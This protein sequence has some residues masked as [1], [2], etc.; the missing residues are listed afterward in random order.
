MSWIKRFASSLRGGRLEQELD[1]ELEFH[2][3]MR[4]REKAAGGATPE[5]ARRQALQRFGS[6]TRAKEACRDESTIAWVAAVRQDLRYAARNLRKNPGFAAAAVTCLAMGIG[7]NAAV[8]SFVNAF[9][10]PALPARVVVV[11]RASGGLISYPELRDWRSLS[12]VFDQVFAY[13]PG[14]RFT[15]GRGANSRHVLGESVTAGY[16]QT[17]GIVP[18]AGRVF[19]ADDETRP[20]AVLGYRF[21]RNHFLGDPAIAG[22]TIWINHELFTIAGVAPASFQGMLAPWSTDVWVTVY[23][24]REILADRRAGGMAVAARLK[25]GVGE[26]QAAAAMNSLDGELARQHPDPQRRERDPLVVQ[27][28]SGLSGSPVWGVFLAMAALLMCVAGI[29]FM[30]ACANVAGLVIARASVRRREILIRLSL[31][32]G[33]WRLVRQ[34]LTESLLL[35]LLGAVFGTAI[36]FAAGDALAGLLPRSISGGFR[37]QHGIDAHVLGFTVALSLVGV[38]I[39]GLLPAL[40]AS[41]QSLADAGRTQTASGWRSPRLR[42]LMIVAQVAASVLVLATAGVFVRSFQK[43]LA[44]D[45]GFDTSHLLTIK[46]DLREMRYPRGRTVDFYSQLRS[47]V[48]GLRGVASASLADVLPLG[49]E[50]TARLAEEGS[51]VA[52]AMVDSSYFRTMGIPVVR[53]RE[54]R[55]EE[56]NVALVN[57][58][59]ARRLWPGQDPIGRPLRLG[60]DK[61]LWQVIGLTATGRYWSLS[62]PARPF[63]YRISSQQAAPVAC[64]AIRTQGPPQALA[65]AIGREIERLNPD[66][67]PMTVQT[68]AERLRAWLEPQ[69]A[70]AVLLSILGLAALGLAIAG[71]YA[72]LA[73]LVAQRTAEIAVR[74]A[75]GASRATVAGMLLR[76]SAV[77]ILAGAVAGIAA[78]AATDRLLAGLAGEVNPLDAATLTGIVSLLAMVGAAATLAP[79]WRAVRIDPAAALRAE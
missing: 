48:A 41:D 31:G 17:L 12:S 65:A 23:L 21:W 6:V 10:F 61:A 46:L 58:A 54:P 67:P 9:L 11:Q 78:S 37:F 38:A 8:F 7:A 49:D 4:T 75:L 62:E 64:L 24:H 18:A 60:N 50:Q 66:L 22:K 39:S 2:L 76:R 52:T 77:L 30:I 57:E 27:R 19:A 47:R 79:A 16:F 56:R 3:A 55:P 44:A 5:E 68:E 13:S 42:S 26:R 59:L 32:A 71:L 53:G 70:A 1:K 34:L 28:R 20:L 51:A 35:G 15:I 14:E 73:Q 72:L 40:R 45:P 36:A 63:L 74:M 33:R 25:S 43:A 29:I 69:R